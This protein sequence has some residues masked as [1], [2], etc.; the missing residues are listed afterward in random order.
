MMN[1]Y[2]GNATLDR[3]GEAVVMLPAYFEV[4]NRGFRYQRTPIGEWQ[5]G[6]STIH[7]SRFAT[8]EAVGP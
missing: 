1:V 7:W 5:C 2:N 8:S 4:L 3:R 6:R